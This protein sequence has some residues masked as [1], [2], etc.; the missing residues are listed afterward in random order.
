[1]IELTIQAAC[2]NPQNFMYL[3]ASDAFLK[4][5]PSKY[6]SVIR[7]KRANQNKVLLLS[8]EKYGKTLQE[9]TDAIRQAFID[10][11]GMTPIQALII[12]AQGGQVAGKNWKEGVYGVGALNVAYFNGHPEITVRPEDGHILNN[13]ADVTDTTKTVYTTIKKQA[14]PYQLFATIDDVVY[15]SQYNKT[16]K[17]YYAQ[18]YSTAEKSYNART[19]NEINAS[20]NADIWGAVLQ[21][22]EKFAQWLI[23]LFAGSSTKETLNASNTLPNQSADGF[24]TESGMTDAATLLLLLA[25]GGTLLAG[26]LGGK[27]KSK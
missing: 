21:S 22:L 18:S 2:Q 27:K 6:A 4:A 14:V 7:V 8:A 23:S 20:D 9:Y 11:Y 15:M 24:V 26:G 17:K 13:G 5:I 3:W 16:Y 1:M 12:L 25:A 10:T 19:G